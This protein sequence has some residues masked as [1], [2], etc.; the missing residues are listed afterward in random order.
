MNPAQPFAKSEPAIRT[1]P[2]QTAHPIKG[3]GLMVDKRLSQS[4]QAIRH[5]NADP[6]HEGSAE[7]LGM[8][9]IGKNDEANS[10]ENSDPWRHHGKDD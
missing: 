2:V 5:G 8:D 9:D 10:N 4:P 3:E 6:H 7:R 1:A